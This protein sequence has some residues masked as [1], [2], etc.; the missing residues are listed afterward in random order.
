[1][2]LQIAL[3]IFF[4]KVNFFKFKIGSEYKFSEIKN[5]FLKNGYESSYLVEKKGQFSQRGDI[6]DIFPPDLEN[7]VR[8]EFFGDELES[9]RFFEVDSQ[10]S[11][12][13]IEEIKIFGNILSGNEFELVEMIS[14][15]NNDDVLIVTENKELVDYKLEEYILLNRDKE[16]LYRKRYE[17]LKKKSF[18]VLAK[19]FSKEQLETFKNKEKLEKLAN[20]NKIFIQTKNYEK[21][22]SD[23]NQILKKNQNNFFVS[24][25][26]LFEGFLSEKNKIFVLTDRELDGYIYENSKK[27]KKSIK[28]KKL[29]QILVDDYVIHIQYGVGIY[30][31]IQTIDEKDYLKVKYADEDILYIPVEKLDRL[32]KYISSDLEPKLFRLGTSGFKRKRKKLE[33]DIQKFA[34]E[35]IKIQARRKRQ[36]GFIYQ[37]D[38]VWQEEF[39]ESFQ[40]WRQ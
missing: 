27:V 30:K 15:I 9:I 2:N 10:I 35:L 21:K 16:N 25:F 32:E 37:K 1:M 6:V 7:P 11:I 20:K 38:T 18:F 34:A 24:N 4:E 39:E 19:N 36:T 33:E 40:N 26:E 14:E 17:N 31:G 12:E 8:F 3:D 29:N 23:Y 5:F 22:L 28:Y 13:K